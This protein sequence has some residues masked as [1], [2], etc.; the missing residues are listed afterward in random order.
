MPPKFTNAEK[1]AYQAKM[2]KQTKQAKGARSSNGKITGKGDYN[3]PLKQIGGMSAGMAIGS[4]LGGLHSGAGRYVGG[5]VGHYAH[6]GLKWL[7]GIGDYKMHMKK[8]K[9]HLGP[10]KNSSVKL[11]ARVPEFQ[12]N[13]GDGENTI[14]MEECIGSII[15]SINYKSVGYRVNPGVSTTFPW[16]STL[17]RGFESYQIKGMVFQ[18]RSFVSSNSAAPTLGEWGISSESDPTQSEPV[19]M[20]DLSNSSYS[21]TERAD[22]PV[23]GMVECDGRRNIGSSVKEISFDGD[24]RDVRWMDA[25]NIFVGTQ[26]YADDTSR[27]GELWVT[28]KVS[29]QR[30]DIKNLLGP[31]TAQF[32]FKDNLSTGTSMLIPAGTVAVNGSGLSARF[33]TNNVLTMP[34]K[35]GNY[36]L[37]MVWSTATSVSTAPSIFSLG[38]DVSYNTN[39][40]GGTG[41]YTGSVWT[42]SNALSLSSA[43]T[44]V[45][46]INFSY[47]AA[48]FGDANDI[49][50]NPP[51]A[52]A[53]AS[54]YTF[55]AWL[56][57]RESSLNLA[58][59]NGKESVE[60]IVENRLRQILGND[61]ECK[62]SGET[63]SFVQQITYLDDGNPPAT[64]T[65]PYS[66]PVPP[67]ADEI[68]FGTGNMTPVPNEKTIAAS[69]A[70]RS[71]L[72]SPGG[73]TALS[74]ALNKLRG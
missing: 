33:L 65:W 30:M 24:I 52:S 8:F 62:E 2:A 57:A 54:K 51:V 55:Q 50:F 22:E 59:E 18:C 37:T 48:T 5:L 49:L 16:L 15:G 39:L 31:N 41:Y 35:P 36:Q 13:A 66:G 9:G 12:S 47:S 38:S 20:Q 28:Y 45:L 6:K 32:F 44:A 34:K 26:G 27:V 58:E 43:G 29:F 63:K 70:A 25:G 11:S 60:T 64:Q 1:K 23:F 7:T 61:N 72:F 17:A 40:N 19:S 74:N 71:S 68:E 53:G 67:Q 10:E 69:N 3:V 4:A 56:H 46:L 21:M 73:S 42:A 14:I